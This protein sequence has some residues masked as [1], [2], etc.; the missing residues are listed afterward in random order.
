MAVDGEWVRLWYAVNEGD[1]DQKSWDRLSQKERLFL[2]RAVRAVKIENK[3]MEIAHA[4]DQKRDMDRL[5]TLE[6]EIVAGN[7][8]DKLVSE[9]NQIVDELAYCYDLNGYYVGQLKWRMRNTMAHA[10]GELT[11]TEQ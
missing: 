7:L 8:S 11:N 10:K 2:V 6:G 5:S 4:H 1:W 3:H 9:Y